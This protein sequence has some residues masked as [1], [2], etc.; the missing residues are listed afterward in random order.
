MDRTGQTRV[1]VIVPTYNRPQLLRVALASIRHLE[2]PD[3]TFEILVGDNG[4]APETPGIAA[5]F[6]AVY[7]KVTKRGASAARNAGLQAATGDYIAFLDDDDAWMPSNIRPQLALLD[8]DPSLD[9]ALGQACTTDASLEQPGAPWPVEDPGRGDGLLRAMLSGYFPQ[10]GTLVVRRR[11]RELIGLFDE[12]LIGGQDLDWQLRIARRRT[13]ACT[14]VPVLLF[15]GRVH[16]SYDQLQ[17]K[18]LWYDRF[19]FLRHSIP[20]WRIW[21]SPLHFLRAYK[22]TLQHPYWYFVT[23]TIAAAA[24]GQRKQALRAVR[25]AFSVFPLL[26]AVH[27]VTRRDFRRAILASALRLHKTA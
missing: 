22:G 14:L 19:I 25:G 26:T 9:G 8:A 1:S 16:G 2:A 7:M 21:N 10:L 20:E 15:R 17:Y 4:S 11:V 5:E 3:L 13:L 23:V 27:V 18:R 6:G 24:A 12:A